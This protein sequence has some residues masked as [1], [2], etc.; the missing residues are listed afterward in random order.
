M[1]NVSAAMEITD[2]RRQREKEGEKEKK[3]TTA[4]EWEKRGRERVSGKE[5][6]E[7]RAYTSMSVTY[8]P[9]YFRTIGRDNARRT[10]T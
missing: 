7:W 10:V 3:K 1:S 2:K 5:S 8:D 4:R 9:R 6:R